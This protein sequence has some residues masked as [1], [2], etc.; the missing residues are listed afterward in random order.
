MKTASLLPLLLLFGVTLSS[1]GCNFWPFKSDPLKPGGQASEASRLGSALSTEDEAIKKAS[2]AAS[3]VERQNDKLL[4]EL[5]SNVVFAREA[6]SGNPE[7]NPK[8]VVDGEL[9]IAEGRL[10][11]VEA[12]ALEL[13]AARARALLM[14][15]GRTA[16]ARSA[17]EKAAQ[18]GEQQAREL[19][20]ARIETAKANQER[21]DARAATLTAVQ[22]Y[23]QRMEQNRAEFDRRLKA[24][25]DKVAA[26]Q[27]RALNVAGA[28]C[29]VL[30]GLGIGFGGP[31]GLKM[32]WPFAVIALMC[33]GL[34]QILGLWWFKWAILTAVLVV[35]AVVV[36]WVWNQFK[37]GTLRENAQTKADSFNSLLQQLIPVLDKA[38]ENAEQSGK[39]LLDRT[40][41]EPLSKKMDREE[42][43]LIHS[44]RAG[45]VSDQ[46]ERET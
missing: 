9:S 15:Q 34:A 44:L 45:S 27:I 7:G 31:A 13:A 19:E 20:A 14:G 10:S 43:S 21:D 39:D 32:T 24:A 38:Y 37:L 25:Q 4:S 46:A 26:D 18:R 23:T 28:V 5:K 16:E 2:E 30:F 22:E 11:G 35:L 33:F 6:N 41:F 8:A 40:V 17:Y 1:S 36:W 12:D 42:K 3:E 29:L